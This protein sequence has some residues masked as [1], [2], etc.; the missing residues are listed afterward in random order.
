[1]NDREKIKKEYAD[2]VDDVC[3]S[4]DWKTHFSMNDVQTK[5]SQIALNYA[6]SIIDEALKRELSTLDE[7]S[8][9]GLRY[10]IEKKEEI[11]KLLQ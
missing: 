10:L 7:V 11:A 1:M 5:Y 9:L 8:H 2:W 4:C 3:E 6:M